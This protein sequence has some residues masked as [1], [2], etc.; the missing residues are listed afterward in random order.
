MSHLKFEFLTRTRT[1][2]CF[3]ERLLFLLT[4]PTSSGDVEHL[5]SQ[6]GTVLKRQHKL[7]DNIS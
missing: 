6:C 7:D 3:Q 2:C 1:T 5:F 4:Q